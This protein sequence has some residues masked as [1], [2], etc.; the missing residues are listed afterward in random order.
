MVN[1]IKTSLQMLQHQHVM[2]VEASIVDTY[3]FHQHAEFQIG[4]C[5]TIIECLENREFS[6]TAISEANVLIEML[7]DGCRTFIPDTIPMRHTW[8]DVKG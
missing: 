3:D 2:L 7:V 4:L 5:D 6:E 1:N 8:L